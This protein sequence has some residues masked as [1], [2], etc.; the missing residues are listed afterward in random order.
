MIDVL[1]AART[2]RLAVVELKADEDIHLPLQ[3]IDYWS[4]VAWHHGRGEFQKSNILP[5]ASFQP[6]LLC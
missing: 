3:G 5:V 2:G 1:T 6:N 4:R